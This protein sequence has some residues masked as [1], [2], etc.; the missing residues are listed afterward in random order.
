[1]YVGMYKKAKNKANER[2][3]CERAAR[4][5][6]EQIAFFSSFFSSVQAG[7][8]H[9]LRILHCPFS[10]LQSRSHR[11][12]RRTA[13]LT[14][15]LAAE[16]RALH[17]VL[18]VDARQ[19]EGR[20]P[21]Q[22]QRAVRL[23]RRVGLHRDGGRPAQHEAPP[24]VHVVVRLQFALSSFDWVRLGLG[25]VVEKPKARTD[26]PRPAP[27]RRG[28][29]PPPSTAGSPA[30]V[31]VVCGFRPSVNQRALQAPSHLLHITHNAPGQRPPSCR[32]APPASALPAA[33][34]PTGRPPARA[35]P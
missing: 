23:Q 31:V 22:R 27:G 4:P 5:G 25:Q 18:I 2:N 29:A 15:R 26:A 9:S 3:K 24:L 1:M 32:P 19:G 13:L 17:R 14:A 8:T 10:L 20:A 21:P 7:C 6:R 16:R 11:R 34:A 33:T 28:A 35:P 12:R 30:R